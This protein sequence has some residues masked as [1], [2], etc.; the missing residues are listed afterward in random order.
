MRPQKREFKSV[1]AQD[2]LRFLTY[3]RALG[4][5][6]DIEEKTLYL[7][8][9]FLM[10]YNI[11]KTDQI[12]FEIIDVFLA[13]RSRQKPRSYNHLL[14]TIRRLFDWLVI[15]G[16]LSTSPVHAKPRRQTNQMVPFIF[17]QRTAKR[18]LQCAAELV[19]N[20]MAP[21]RGITYRTIFS[22][23]YGLGLRVGEISRLCHADIDFE[24][25]LLVI[26]KT[27]FSKDRLVP[28]GPRIRNILQ[29]YLQV[30]QQ[31]GAS[32]SSS[33][34]VFS[35]VQGRPIHPGT[36]SQAFHT[37]IPRLELVNPYPL[38]RPIFPLYL[39]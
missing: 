39:V 19:D 31:H 4:R 33:S 18:L 27:K 11:G 30:R 38:S 24:R 23:L 32:F 7:L 14:G 9:S 36:I 17:N 25:Q 34:P 8:D 29:S 3:K 15:Q 12:S 37:L 26:R 28:F 22:L 1:I 2:I 16:S 13:S 21:L 5:R 6:Y 10:R 20:P 35:F